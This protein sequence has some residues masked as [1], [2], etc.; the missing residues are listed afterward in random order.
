MSRIFA[1]LITISRREFSSS[2]C[3]FDEA[4]QGSGRTT[5]SILNENKD[6]ILVNGFSQYGFILNNEMRVMGPAAIFPDGVLQWNIASTLTVDEN[7]FVLFELLHPKPDIVFFGYGAATGQM[8][9]SK[10][11]GGIAGT[12]HQVCI[13]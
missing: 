1:R 10:G 6:R 8:K 5:V 7:A 3:R 13:S 11:A 12:K 2:I 9:M 4:Y